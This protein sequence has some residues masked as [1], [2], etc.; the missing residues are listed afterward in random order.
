MSVSK[1]RY[2]EHFENLEKRFPGA[3]FVVSCFNVK[4]G[5]DFDNKILCDHDY[6]LCDDEYTKGKDDKNIRRNPYYEDFFLI[7]KKEGKEHIYF[8]D[9]IDELINKN[10]TRLGVDHKFLENIKFIKESRNP[11]SI[12]CYSLSWGS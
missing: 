2:K 11:N 1:K 7:R 10:F 8:A 5:D 4:D 12:P 9:V 3:L 6:I